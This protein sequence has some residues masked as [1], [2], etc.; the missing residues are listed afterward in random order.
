MRNIRNDAFNN[1]IISNYIMEKIVT[2]P[3]KAI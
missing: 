1:I 3:L 2:N